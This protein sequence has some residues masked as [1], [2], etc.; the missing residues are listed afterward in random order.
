[1]TPVAVAAPP[2][3]AGS[4]PPH[5]EEAEASVLGAILLT[6]QALD[7]VL[8]E[9]GL[10]ADHFYRPR[11]QLIFASMIR[12]KEKAEPEAVDAL[13]V[14]D[15]LRR[16]GELE[17]A[18]GEA[19]VHSLPTVV[20]AVGAFMHYARI[21][22]DH[23]LLRSLLYTT[24]EIQGEVLTHRGEPRE[25]IERAEAALFRIGHDGGTR[26]RCAR[27]RTV[28]HE[29]IDKLEELSRKDVGLTGT[30][31]G[32]ADLDEPDRRVP[33]GKPDRGRGSPVDGQVARSPPTSPR[34]RRSTTACRSRCSRWRCRRPSWPTASSRLRPRSRATS[35]GRA[36]CEAIAGRRS[37]TPRRSWPARRS[38]ST[39]R[40][41]SACWR[42]AP[43]RAGLHRAER[44]RPAGG[45][46]SPAGARGHPLGQ[47][48][49]AGRPDQPWT[50]DPRPRAGDPGDRRVA[51]LACRGEPQPADPM[52]SDLRESGQLEQDADLVMFV[53]REEYYLKEE[54]ERPG[55]ADVIIAKHRNG[56]I[57]QVALT[58]PVALPALHD[59]APRALGRRGRTAQRSRLSCRCDR[60]SPRP[61][62]RAAVPVRRM[63]RQRLDPRRGAQRRPRPCRCRERGDRGVERAPAGGHPEAAA[64]ARRSTAIPTSIRPSFAHVRR[65]IAEIDANV[66]AGRGLWFHGTSAP[67]RPRWRC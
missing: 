51:A 27:S 23:A 31:S 11:H 13:T 9:V 55:E 28:L 54:S 46:L 43:R 67:A 12:L 10:K 8:L 3:S 63:R 42:C 52:L 22:Q 40:A 65:F 7:S 37:S 41:T 16:A 66:D 57:G 48:R 59:A 25:L 39:T 32:F 26:A 38:S 61:P 20:P 35:C 14:C 15:D 1:M 36:A 53:Y 4:V 44:P 18:G 50:E 45:G 17:E 2:D 62:P 34:T 60:S 58:L 19:Y 47:P 56:P 29:E 33:A 21:V 64:R 6:E 49:G 5:N 24:R 30:P